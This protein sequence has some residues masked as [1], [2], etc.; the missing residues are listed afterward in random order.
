MYLY[1]VSYSVSFI[2]RAQLLN[3]RGNLSDTDKSVETDTFTVCVFGATFD[4]QIVN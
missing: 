2:A 3:S 1:N 4:F